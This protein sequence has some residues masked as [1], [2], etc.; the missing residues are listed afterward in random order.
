MALMAFRW[1]LFFVGFAVPAWAGEPTPAFEPFEPSVAEEDIL[2]FY[3]RREQDVARTIVRNLVPELAEFD[4]DSKTPFHYRHSE[5]A[6]D[7]FF[8][9][10]VDGRVH[11]L[12][13]R[14]ASL[15]DAAG[16]CYGYASGIA[17]LALRTS[18]LE[19][20]FAPR[21]SKQTPL[22]LELRRALQDYGVD[23]TSP[24]VVRRKQDDG[25]LFLFTNG[26]A[27]NFS[28]VD[29]FVWP[30]WKK[31]S[32]ASFSFAVY[33]YAAD[34]DP[35]RAIGRRE[36]TPVETFGSTHS[37]HCAASAE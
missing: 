1:A 23:E 31:G 29:V 6:L 9:R 4:V 32:L 21:D 3:H 8:S 30:Q 35:H 12:A 22:T 27:A 18:G 36:S 19:A 7:I 17:A 13:V 25:L 20:T 24:V 5:K 10:A 2:S 28:S 34:A 16:E 33:A 26:P 37:R 14:F 15:L 11:V